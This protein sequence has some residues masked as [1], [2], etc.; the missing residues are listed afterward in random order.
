MKRTANVVWNGDGEDGN[1][2]LSTQ[3]GAINNLPYNFKM[4][5]KNDDGKLGTNPEELIAAAHAGCFNMKLS[6]ILNENGYN[7]EVL[8]TNS[9]L[10]FIDG[11][12]ESIQL[13]LSA[14]VPNI[15]D[16]KFTELA[17]LAK[18]ECPISNVLNCKINL[19]TDLI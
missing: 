12:I 16:K 6:F 2:T 4:R 15:T 9:E 10:T 18:N 11:D 5:F 8:T 17:F 13:S 1:G 3:S 14:K 19:Q 7:P